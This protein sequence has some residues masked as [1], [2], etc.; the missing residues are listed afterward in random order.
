[1]IEQLFANWQDQESVEL[2]GR[3][4]EPGFGVNEH[5]GT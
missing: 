3:M 2:C 4:I 1:L 5:C